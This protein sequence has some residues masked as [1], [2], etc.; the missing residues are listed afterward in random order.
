MTVCRGHDAPEYSALPTPTQQLNTRTFAEVAALGYARLVPIIPPDAP[1]S[2]G[3]SL[4]KRVGTPQDGRGKTPGIRGS[5][6]SGAWFSFDWVRH[7]ANAADLERW[8]HMGA[9]I[10][11]K[12]GEC[13]L[14]IDADTLDP[15]CAEAIRRIVTEHFGATPVRIGR[16][17]KA[18]YLIRTT[19][20]IPY[21]RVEFG[22]TIGEGRSARRASR[23]EL[24]T[25]GRQ[26]VAYG[27][28]P[29]TGKP[30]TWPEALMPFDQL[31]E[32]TPA[33]I[34]AF[35]DALREA[36]PNASEM[37]VS[38]GAIDVDQA[39]LAGDLETVRAAVLATPNTDEH[40]PSREDYCSFG[41]LIK[42]ALPD[43]P[44]T[45]FEL[46]AEWAD[47]W[48]SADHETNDPNVVAADWARMKPPFK[49][50]APAL[51]RTAAKLS[52]G[53]FDRALADLWFEDL[54][55]NTNPFAAAAKAEQGERAAD[56]FRIWG[57][58][59]I[60]LRAPAQWLIARHIP[61]TGVG[62][63]YSRPGAGKSFLALDMAL[64]IASGAREWHGESVCARE[65]ARVLYLAAEGGYGFRNR[66]AAW[67]VA[68]PEAGSLD[69]FGLIETSVNFMDAGDVEKLLRTVRQAGGA[70]DLVIVDT[71]SR[72]MPGADENLQKDMTRFVSACDL[73]RETCGG[74]VLGVHH[75]GK[76]GDM[77]GSTVLLGAGDFVFRLDRERGAIV[78]TLGCEKQKE[79]EDGWESAFAFDLT[80]TGDG[81]T[82]LVP[83]RV[84]LEG[85]GQCFG[86]S[87]GAG[88]DRHATPDMCARILRAIERAWDAGEPW[89]RSAQSGERRAA[90][91]LARDF[92][93]RAV[94]G[95]RLME[96][97]EHM[98]VVAI[99]TVDTRSKRK[100]YRV[101]P[102]A[103]AL[104]QQNTVDPDVFG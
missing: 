21:Q 98:G 28:H 93:L 72:A 14:A 103:H 97:W 45:A 24:L 53:T 33:G 69:G 94:D 56:V 12:T 46:F 61:K 75:A 71:V 35:M 1:I 15:G 83:S 70:F 66:I 76:S 37:I 82:S 51:Y 68:H 31:P 60:L 77:R 10:G 102:A 84:S 30:Y 43:D 13:L 85:V 90:R 18:L 67:M 80:H 64:H 91:C 39:S 27:T 50:G 20:P 26:F 99:A 44:D 101:T 23:C 34:Q 42:A 79:A 32:A 47:R 8:Q 4:Y 49:A 6:G 40:F 59:D 78:G 73:V 92:G 17:P 16:A 81:E 87:E 55:A 11:I 5:N 89:S 88:A 41:Y 63:L 95:E 48:E 2:E 58:R 7:E 100:G 74:A 57:P 54:D 62:F 38:G 19:E 3:S 65:N 29:G 22:P 36:L 86:D 25:D 9:G 52:G 104:M 96:T